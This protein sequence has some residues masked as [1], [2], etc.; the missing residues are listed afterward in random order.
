ML[1]FNASGSRQRGKP[2][3]DPCAVDAWA[4]GVTLYLLVTG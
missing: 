3:Y 2:P 1:R 4:M